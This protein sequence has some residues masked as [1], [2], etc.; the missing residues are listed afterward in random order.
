M[1]I[2]TRI[3]A[4]LVPDPEARITCTIGIWKVVTF[5][6]HRPIRMLFAAHGVKVC[7]ILVYEEL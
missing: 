3:R 7:Y 1:N 6:Q 5:E 4:K 2:R